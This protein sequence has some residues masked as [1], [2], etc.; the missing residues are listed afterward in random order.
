MKRVLKIAICIIVLILFSACGKKVLT[1]KEM[2]KEISK[3]SFTTND[4]TKRL[5][6]ATIK[7]AYVLNNGEYQFEYYEYKDSES[8]KKS[9]DVQIKKLKE[10]NNVKEKRSGEY[11]KATSETEET[12]TVVVKNKNT[13]VYGSVSKEYK[14]SLNKTLSKLGY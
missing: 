2:L 12:Y 7:N 6:D 13:L 8:A 11:I 5:R 3:T 14:R 9:Y 1:G 10:D 4:I